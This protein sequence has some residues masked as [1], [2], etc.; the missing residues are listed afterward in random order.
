[1]GETICQPHSCKELIFKIYKK[2]L[3]LN[4]NETV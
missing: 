1:M 4:S 2:L 3:H